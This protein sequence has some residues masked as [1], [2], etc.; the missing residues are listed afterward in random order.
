MKAHY[1][2]IKMNTFVMKEKEKFPSQLKI[3]L[4]ET[5]WKASSPHHLRLNLQVPMGI[6]ALAS[7]VRGNPMHEWERH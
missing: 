7:V 4:R 2:D 6:C 1:L 3:F 5:L